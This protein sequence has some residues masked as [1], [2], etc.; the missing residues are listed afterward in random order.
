MEIE[1]RKQLGRQAAAHSDHLKDVLTA[2]QQ[3]LS[4]EFNRELHVKILEE[5]EKFQ[6]EVAGWI[7]RLRGIETA[8]EGLEN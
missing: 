8:V 3:E 2:Q 5:R 1:V 6:G 7:A 4:Q